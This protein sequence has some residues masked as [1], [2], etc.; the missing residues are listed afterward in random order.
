VKPVAEATKPAAEPAKP[1][2]EPVKPVAEATKPAEPVKPIKPGKGEK[3]GKQ[4][5]V[6][7]PKPVE[8]AK[9]PAAEPVQV[10]VAGPA[11][12]KDPEPK[13]ADPADGASKPP[14]KGPDQTVAIAEPE[15]APRPAPEN[16]TRPPPPQQG[17]KPQASGG[18]RTLAYLTGG[19]GVALLG[20]GA[21]FALQAA[22][23]DSQL[24]STAHTRAAADDLINQS[25]SKH[26]LGSVLLGAGAAALVTGAVLFLVT[27][28]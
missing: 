15:P 26:L 17:Q 18:S 14:P 22:S 28:N 25:K 19:A 3:P 5:A 16:A 4:V 27:G 24:T 23:T 11:A 10:A 6:V 1:A 20:G 2:P 7:Q 9:T 8:P 13:R 12:Q 21:L